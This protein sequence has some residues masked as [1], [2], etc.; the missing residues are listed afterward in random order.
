MRNSN[1]KL[2][3]DNQ[4]SFYLASYNIIVSC[5]TNDHAS[6]RSFDEPNTIEADKKWEKKWGKDYDECKDTKIDNWYG[7][8]GKPF[9]SKF[10]ETNERIE[11]DFFTKLFNP[12]INDL[13]DDD[14]LLN[15]KLMGDKRHVKIDGYTGNEGNTKSTTYSRYILAVWPKKYD[16]RFLSKI[17]I[18][19]TLNKLHELLDSGCDEKIFKNK[20]FDV[21]QVFVNLGFSGCQEETFEKIAS[22]FKQCKTSELFKYL[23]KNFKSEFPEPQLSNL[24]LHYGW[25]DLQESLMVYLKPNARMYEFNLAL[26][27]VNNSF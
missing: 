18:K 12:N 15:T 24:I 22:I 13:N 21:I 2:S 8:D 17:N 26:I 4:L 11:P 3:K 5:Y 14:W 10:E 7:P 6:S 9:E 25:N 1:E 16:Y 23:L 20:F 19:Y 27:K